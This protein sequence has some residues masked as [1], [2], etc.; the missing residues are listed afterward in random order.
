MRALLADAQVWLRSALRLLLEHEANVEVVGEA[1]NILTLP[2]SISRLRP[3]LL[4]LDWQL[5]GLYT[6]SA[7][8]RLLNTVRTIDPYLYI[9]AL[10]NDDNATSCLLL[11]ADAFINKAEPPEQVLTVLRQAE[12]RKLS[13]YRPATDG[14][15]LL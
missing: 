5:P 14:H 1:G 3:D 4:F 8:Q 13:P 2:L 15:L 6:N 10:T 7:R 9:I 12:K 11:G